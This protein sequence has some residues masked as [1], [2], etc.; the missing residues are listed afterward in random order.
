MGL[1]IV[2]TDADGLSEN[3]ADAVTGFVVPRREPGA[4]TSGLATLATDPDLRLRLGRAARERA[5]RLFDLPRQLD[6]LESLY[7]LALSLPASPA[8]PASPDLEAPRAGASLEALEHELAGLERRRDALAKHVRGRRV[9]ARVRSDTDRLLPE[10]ATVLVVS[11]GDEELLRIGVRE[12]RHFPQ[13]RD[14][15]YAGHHPADS[16][17]AVE[18]LESLRHDGASHLVIPATSDWWLE[19]Y[20][21]FRQH[22][23]ERYVRLFSDPDSCVIYALHNALSAAGQAA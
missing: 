11:R 1:P 5:E 2:C 17:A 23:E 10:A 16:T 6:G 21:G 3:V 18:H 4:L 7:E 13:T 9:A 19:H 15:V 8:S 14:G 22:L 12:G 20:A